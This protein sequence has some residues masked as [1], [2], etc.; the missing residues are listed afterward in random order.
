[1]KNIIL[2]ILIVMI[3]MLVGIGSA[4]LILKLNIFDIT[5]YQRIFVIIISGVVFGCFAYKIISI[6]ER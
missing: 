1:M 3:W 5:T 6:L 4:D 2:D